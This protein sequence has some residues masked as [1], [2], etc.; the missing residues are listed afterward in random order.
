[1]EAVLAVLDRGTLSEL[2]DDLYAKC[3]E[4]IAAAARSESG[5]V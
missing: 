3:V 2:D 4:G 1:M 5:L